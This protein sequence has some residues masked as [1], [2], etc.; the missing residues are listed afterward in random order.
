MGRRLDEVHNEG[1]SLVV[2]TTPWQGALVVCASGTNINETETVPCQS[3]PED[4]AGL[5][6]ESRT[7]CRE[8]PY[9]F[10]CRAGIAD[11]VPPFAPRSAQE[12]VAKRAGPAVNITENRAQY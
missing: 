8:L 7:R 6:S 12:E 11:P 2:E 5:M 10:A 4:P 3:H 9:P 1:S